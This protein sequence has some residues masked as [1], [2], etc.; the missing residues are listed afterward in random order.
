[1]QF[2]KSLLLLAALASTSLARPEGHVR[3]QASSTTTSAAPST[4]STSSSSAGPGF[5]AR[6]SSSGSGITYQGNVGDPYGSNIIEI[7]SDDA[8]NYKH[9]AKISGEN[10]EPWDLIFFNK[11]GPDGKMN[12]WFG[13]SALELTLNSGETNG[14]MP[15]DAGGGY[16][17]TWGE[18]DFSSTGNG[19]WSGFDVSA[20]VAQN[21]GETV[22]GMKICEQG[23]GTCSSISPGAESVDNAYTTA[24]T[25]IGGIGGNISGD[26]NVVLEVTVD[27]QG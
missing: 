23:S 19:G 14:N 20:I 15:L 21:A 2:T 3:R 9:V 18:F 27:W 6:T 11:Y 22:Q 26:G 8:S 24:E 10:S 7:S 12:G 17:S 13:F 25:D 1:M 16:A 5:G 4:S